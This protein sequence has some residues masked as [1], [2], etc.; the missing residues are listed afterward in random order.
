MPTLPAIID[1][2]RFLVT[3]V[4]E[5]VKLTCG[6]L[7]EINRD[8]MEK[9]AAKDDYIDNLKT[10]VENL[11]FSR[12]HSD[13][14]VDEEEANAV[15]SLHV[16]CV[17]LERIADFCV[18]I[19]RQTDYM[20]DAAFIHDYDYQTM[21]TVIQ[22]G[23]SRIIPVFDHRNLSGAL[24][25]CKMENRLDGLYK[26]SFDRIMG[27]MRRKDDI[28]NLITVLFIFRY[29]ERVGDS[30]L[31]IGEALIFSII[32]DRIKIRHFEALQQTLSDSGFQ[33][34]L[35]DI[36][37]NSIWGSRSGCRIGRVDSKHP[38][39]QGEEDSRQKAQGLFKEGSRRKIEK[40]RE[41]IRQWETIYPG[42]APRVF[43]FYEKGDTASMLVEFLSGCTL[44]QVILT[45]EEELLANVIF[46]FEQTLEEIWEGTLTGGSAPID[47]MKQLAARL[48]AIYRVH[49]GLRRPERRIDDLHILSS[50]DL[51]DRCTRIEAS[52]EAPFS[53]FIHGD[54]NVNNIIYSHDRQRI[55][56]IDLYRSKMADYI[57]DAS[58]FLIS[59]FRL[60][61]FETALRDR[62]NR[63][64]DHFFNR[65]SAF[66]RRHGDGGF[67]A[68]M[69][70]ALARSFYTS[71]R[72]ELNYTFAREMYLRSQFLMEKLVAHQGDW[73]SYQLPRRILFY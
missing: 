70:L 47:Y 16:I 41:S 38:V 22:E 10:T 31:N 37:F 65:F 25:L 59:N 71:S 50:D 21:F 61:A 7:N 42:I 62:I 11:C 33:G 57:Q 27:E 26:E 30:L 66:A 1:N 15:R 23:L 49:P 34:N 12:I 2:T 29:L 17:N 4:Q 44:E 68:R 14:H 48:D 60:P 55:N 8:L 5:Q 43:G 18:N 69:T 54:F 6:L 67:D 3:E 39:R 64:I 72:F 46:V 24:D 19:G 20:S 36:D 51:I 9:I 35:T 13:A 73:E 56:Y 28:Q 40:E 53:I 52:I 32:G 58:V 45:E 63:V